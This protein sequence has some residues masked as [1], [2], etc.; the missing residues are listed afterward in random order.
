[1]TYDAPGTGQS[2]P[3]SPPPDAV[4]GESKKPFYRRWWVIAIAAIVAIAIIGS[5]LGG[6]GDDDDAALPGT[7]QQVTSE[8]VSDEPPTTPSEE[9]PSEAT[10]DPP[11]S[12][13]VTPEPPEPSEPPANDYDDTYGA[14][15]VINQSGSGDSTIDIAPG[16]VAAVVTATHQGS[17]N[18][19]V[20]A[21]DAANQPTG[22]LLVNTIGAYTGITAYGLS[23]FGEP[24]KLQITADGPWTRLIAPISSA[25]QLPAQ[26]SGE[27]DAVY[28][29]DG[30]AVDWA[31]EHTGEANFVVLQYVDPFPNLAVNEIG[32]YSG[33]VPAQAGPS[34]VAIQ[35]DGQWSIASS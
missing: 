15:E 22:D 4:V 32:N 34:V 2:P 23:G 33:T 21:L 11:S 9:P 20:S 5:A 12:P 16:V 13:A 17:A 10:Q 7:T 29:Y 14:F 24:S 28:V 35:A 19:A 18:F 1:M 8:P 3:S 30:G 25:P 31:I 26:A 6:G 27:G